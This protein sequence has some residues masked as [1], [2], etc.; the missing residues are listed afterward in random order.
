MLRL[1]TDI[2]IFFG[3]NINPLWYQYKPLPRNMV[4][5]YDFD[6]FTC[7]TNLPLVQ[8]YHWYKIE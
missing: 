8:K 2:E 4:R 6:E 3:F 5:D 7:L 1:R